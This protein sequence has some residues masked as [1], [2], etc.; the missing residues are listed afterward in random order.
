[1]YLDTENLATEGVNCST[2]I[3]LLPPYLNYIRMCLNDSW[4]TE[5]TGFSFDAFIM[6]YLTHAKQARHSGDLDK[7]LVA[8]HVFCLYVLIK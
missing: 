5:N 3:V 2:I 8:V 4:F 7:Q 6:Q 1:M